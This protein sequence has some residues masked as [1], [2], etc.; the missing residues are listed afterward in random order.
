[1]PIITLTTRIRAPLETCF[2]LARSIEL[3]VLSTKETGEKAVGGVTTGL[4]ELG[5]E[6]TWEAIHF[7]MRQRLTSRITLFDRPYH[8]RD[9]MVRGAFQ[10]FDHDH[11]FEY[12]DCTTTMTDV[13]DY[14]S[15]LGF[16]GKLADILFLKRYMERLLCKRAEVIR[17]VAESAKACS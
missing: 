15:P 1:M 6:V 14:I 9:S 2:D 13:F 5:E 4:I 7:G 12:V 17:Q 16:L 8:F 11:L 10:K 3:H